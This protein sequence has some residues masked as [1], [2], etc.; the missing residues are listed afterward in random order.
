MGQVTTFL[1]EEIRLDSEISNVAVIM[2]QSLSAEFSFISC[3]QLPNTLRFTLLV[4]ACKPWPVHHFSRQLSYQS[5]TTNTN[6]IL[7]TIIQH[8]DSGYP[9]SGSTI[10]FVGAQYTGKASES[11]R[12]YEGNSGDSSSSNHPLMTGHRILV[13]S[14]VFTSGMT[15]SVLAYETFQTE[16]TFLESTSLLQQGAP[17]HYH[18]STI[19]LRLYWPG[20]YERAQPKYILLHS[21]S[22][23][24]R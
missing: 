2:I 5:W 9:P 20:L 12:N 15:K 13:T 11:D 6:G 1:Q 16:S 10:E 3:C 24:H 17:A 21:T 8:G 19:P 4:A 18:G 22:T 7:H 23:T 14:T